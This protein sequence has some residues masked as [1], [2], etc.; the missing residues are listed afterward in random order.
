MRRTGRATRAC[1]LVRRVELRR[2]S[3]DRGRGA[4]GDRRRHQARKDLD[5]ERGYLRAPLHARPGRSRPADSHL[6]RDARQQFPALADRLR[7]DLRY[8]N[9]LARLHAAISTS[10][11]SISRNASAAT[12]A[13]AP[14]ANG[15]GQRSPPPQH[16]NPTTHQAGADAGCCLRARHRRRPDPHRRCAWCGAGPPALLAGVAAMVADPGAWWSS[17]NLG[18]RVGLRAIPAKWTYCLRGAGLFYAQYSRRGAS[19]NA[20]ARRAASRM[21]RDAARQ[22][23][24]SDRSRAAS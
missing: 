24:L 4:P 3:G 5:E 16:T 20:L 1:S 6:G 14:P 23:A 9:A 18:D 13:S 15:A 11:S 21:V 2:P 22:A 8:G 17:S 12:A 10:P 19:R 7:G